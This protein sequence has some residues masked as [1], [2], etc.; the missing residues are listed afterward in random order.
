M[1]LIKC[2]ECGKEFSDK[3][4]ACPN[5]GCPTSEILKKYDATKRTE[6]TQTD[7][8][9][10]TRD[11]KTK[12]KV[13]AIIIGVILIA[14]I[15]G[16][17]LT[18]E[19]RQYKKANKL[20][21]DKQYTEAMNL[22]QKLGNYRESEVLAEECK[23]QLTVDASFIRDLASA[24]SLRWDKVNEEDE[25]DDY[26]EVDASYEYCQIELDRIEKYD[27]EIFENKDLQKCAKLYIEYLR[28]AQNATK[29]YTI[30]YDHY[31]N[32]WDDVYEKRIM[33]LQTFVQEYGLEVDE[34][35]KSDLED[36]MSD[37]SAATEKK[38]V[39]DSIESMCDGFKVNCSKDKW[40]NTSYKIVMNNITELD[41]EWFN[42]DVNVLDKK[43]NI[44]TTGTGAEVENWKSGVEVTTEIWFDEDIDINEVS[45][46]YNPH[47]SAGTY[48]N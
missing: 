27:N 10:S 26:D 4:P 44:I 41:F 30:D 11:S 47:Y 43:G 34:Q 20:M 22:Y 40:G 25:M 33:L 13:I 46:E 17:I 29:Y 32:I 42:V 2:S 16:T 35:H 7:N 9:K 31:E 6:G 39:L 45:F 48:T 38:S 8:I 19:S 3:A 18:N 37:A 24:L 14:T 5:C 15:I 23:E 28:K 36:I 21:E 1:A 12:G